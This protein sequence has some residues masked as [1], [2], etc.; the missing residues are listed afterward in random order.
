MGQGDVTGLVRPGC[1]GQT[2]LFLVRFPTGQKKFFKAS[3][4][5][6]RTLA[7]SM[8][9]S[10]HKSWFHAV[11]GCPAHGPFKILSTLP[12]NQGSGSFPGKDAVDNDLC[13]ESWL[14]SLA[15]PCCSRWLGGSK[16]GAA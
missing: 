8:S 14:H 1:W 11:S 5:G 10:E 16:N 12:R 13:I 3:R 15:I 7:A 9:F 6:Q 4:S 2:Q